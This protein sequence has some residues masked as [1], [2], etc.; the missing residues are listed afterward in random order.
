MRHALSV[1]LV[2]VAALFSAT[3]IQA[4]TIPSPYQYVETTQSLGAWAGYLNTSTGNYDTGPRSAPF[5]G[6]RYTIRFTGPLSGTAGISAVPTS[7]TVFER[8]TVS[9]DSI[10]LDPI[11]EADLLLLMGEAGLRFSFTGPRTWNGLAPYAGLGIG[12]MSNV[13]SRPA[14]EEEIES[15]QRVS[16]GPAFALGV[17]AGTEWFLSERF[18]LRGEASNQIWR[19][20]TPEGLT[21]LQ[22]REAQWTNNLGISFGAALH[23]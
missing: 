19:L 3:V 15:N 5:F 17:N 7:R 2:S 14:V 18:S 9:A 13:L 6:A 21:R 11:G 23:F 1:T 10:E 4:Q 12:V 8:V 20:T 22:R 16:F